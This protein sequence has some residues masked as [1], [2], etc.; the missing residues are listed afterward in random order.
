[1]TVTVRAMNCGWQTGPLGLFLEGETGRIRVPTPSFLIE[2][3]KGRVLFD[4]GLHR[5]VKTDPKGR[6]GAIASIFD[7]E[8]GPGDDVAS[9]LAA[10]DVDAGAIDLLVLSHLHYDHCGGCHQL[11]NATLV[12]QRREWEAGQDADSA[13][14][15]F[16]DP[17]N[18]DLGH[19]LRLVDGE[20]DLFG[21]GALVCLPTY[22]HT[23]GHQSLRIRGEAGDVVLTADCCYLRRSLEEMHLPAVAHDREAMVRS[24]A[25]LRALQQA[26]VRL[27]FGHDPEQWQT[28]PQAPEPL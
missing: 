1:M 10:L 2:H 13:A 21:D 7:V 18:Y 4:S 24:L 20:H 26:G 25:G 12:V 28:L 22:G 8:A 17:R 27:V 3:P 11:P 15:N 6:L 9:R 14:S 5:E 19:A 16:Y 23:P